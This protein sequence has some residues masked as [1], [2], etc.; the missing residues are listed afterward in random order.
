M[1][2]EDVIIFS[3]S[4]DGL[5]LWLSRVAKCTH[6]RQPS[7]QREET[8]DFLANC[9][10]YVYCQAQAVRVNTILLHTHL[11]TGVHYL[12]RP[13]SAHPLLY[14]L[15]YIVVYCCCP[16]LFIVV[17]HEVLHI[18]SSFPQQLVTIIAYTLHPGLCLHSFLCNPCVPFKF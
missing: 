17:R 6:V 13:C 14:I 16:L 10:F 15:L 12:R 4:H 7:L 5:C 8:K 1:A 11:P 9:W 18:S 3:K 2:P